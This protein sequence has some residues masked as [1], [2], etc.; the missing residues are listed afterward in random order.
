MLGITVLDQKT[1]YPLR[2]RDADIVSLEDSAYHSLGGSWIL[3]CIIRVSCQHAAEIL[4]PG[5]VLEAVHNDM[6]DLASAQFLRFGWE[7]EEGIGFPLHEQVKRVDVTRH[8]LDVLQGE[9]A[10]LQAP[11]ALPDE[12]PPWLNLFDRSDF[13]SFVAERLF[14]GRVRIVNLGLTLVAIVD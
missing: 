11:A 4:R 5:S 3:R 9:L 12:F 6:A 14:P 8:P 1:G 7:T 10:S 13:L 2:L